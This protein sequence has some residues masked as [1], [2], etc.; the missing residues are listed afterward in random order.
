ML[1]LYIIIISAVL[2]SLCT[3]SLVYQAVYSAYFRKKIATKHNFTEGIMTG[4]SYP[5]LWIAYGLI[6]IQFISFI[7]FTNSNEIIIAFRLLAFSISVFSFYVLK[8]HTPPLL[9]LWFGK[10]AFWD[11]R[12]EGGKHLYTEIYGVK[13]HKKKN[14]TV[15]NSQQ[16]YKITFFIK[17]KCFLLV[18]KRYS[19][20]MTAHQ[21]STLAD[22][23]DFKNS[24]KPK[25]SKK[26]LLYSILTPTLIFLISLCFFLQAISTGV[27]NS[28]R[29]TEDT[30][31]FSTPSS[32]KVETISEISKVVTD[33]AKLYVY[34]ENIG[35]I[36]TYTTDGTFAFSI[37]LPHSVLKASDIAYDGS[38]ILYRYGGELIYYSVNGEFIS[39]TTYLYSHDELFDVCDV[40]I[41]DKIVSFNENEVKLGD[42]IIVERPAYSLLFSTQFIWPITALLVIALFGLRL[43]T[44]KT[45]DNE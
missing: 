36:N 44:F 40:K 17:G 31:R 37:S 14:S 35:V 24:E 32:E 16:I 7:I 6:L 9:A 20:K 45:E 38:Q 43:Y 5:L 39:K 12:G 25:L 1:N 26:S 41:G 34:Y 8:S 28:V 10:T 22:T 33:G 3:F 23:I 30:E 19:C 18:P 27:F 42:T 21:I 4:P 2:L 11:N 13:V 29:Y 15:I